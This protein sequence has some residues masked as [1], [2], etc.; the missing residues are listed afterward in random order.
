MTKEVP[1]FSLTRG[2][3]KAI[4]LLNESIYTKLFLNTSTPNEEI[5]F[6]YKIYF[7][8]IRSPVL[9]TLPND[10]DFWTECCKYFSQETQ[11]K[12]GNNIIITLR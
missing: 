1:T 8:M 9:K 7:H 5:L 3:V 12:T 10:N 2:T 6:P 4:E 11:G